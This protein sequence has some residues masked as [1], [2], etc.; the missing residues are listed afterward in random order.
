MRGEIAIVVP[1]S[2][3]PRGASA[4]SKELKNNKI[5]VLGKDQDLIL[6]KINAAT[7]VKLGRVKNMQHLLD[8]RVSPAVMKKLPVKS[9]RVATLWNWSIDRQ[10]KR[11]TDAS[12]KGLLD[13]LSIKVDR[14]GNVTDALTKKSLGK[15]DKKEVEVKKGNWYLYMNYSWEIIPGLF[16]YWLKR[17]TMSRTYTSSARTN[18]QVVDHIIAEVYGPHH[19]AYQSRTNA[20]SA[21]A[22]DWSYIWFGQSAWVNHWSF[23]R[24]GS[25]S[26]QLTKRA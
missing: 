1:K 10:G 23:A 19:Y 22:Y 4:L 24:L 17:A 5:K 2:I 13:K 9:R 11:I 26:L 20:V 21:Y 8:D 25:A 15:V 6:I 12:V 18:Y 16:G 14:Q 7:K 3:T